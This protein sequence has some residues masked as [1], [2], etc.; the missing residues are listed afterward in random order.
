[1]TREPSVYM[2]LKMLDHLKPDEMTKLMDNL[3]AMKTLPVG[4]GCT[5]SHLAHVVFTGYR[6]CRRHLGHE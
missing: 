3:G 6:V 4:S 1:M 5:G 2:C